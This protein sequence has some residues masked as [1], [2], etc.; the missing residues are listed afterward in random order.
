MQL[1][2]N[3]YYRSASVLGAE[4]QKKNKMISVLKELKVS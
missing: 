1:L 2:V 3:G 4:A